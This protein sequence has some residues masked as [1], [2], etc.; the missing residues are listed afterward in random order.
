MSDESTIVDLATQELLQVLIPLPPE[1][2]RCDVDASFYRD[3]EGKWRTQFVLV[4][5][6][7][8]KKKDG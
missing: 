2:D 6:V 7:V 4:K 3:Q 5:D 1:S 8:P